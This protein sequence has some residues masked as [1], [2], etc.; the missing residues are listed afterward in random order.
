MNPHQLR[1]NIGLGFKT[2]RQM[3]SNVVVNNYT[4]IPT[5][6]FSN[7]FNNK[8]HKTKVTKSNI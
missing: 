8:L 3:T 6:W 1:V 7:N 4:S 2:V 5:A